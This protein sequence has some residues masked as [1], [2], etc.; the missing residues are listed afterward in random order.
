MTNFKNVL[1]VFKMMR[2]FEPDDHALLN[3]LRSAT[4]AEIELLIETV[5]PQKR[6]TTKQTRKASKS[7]RAMSLGMAIQDAKRSLSSLRCAHTLVE[8][9]TVHGPCGELEINAIHDKT[10]GYAGYHEFQPTQVQAAAG[11]E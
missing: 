1:R 6:S 8:G 10:A 3:T 5:G 2:E 4:E 11:G 9:D 7:R